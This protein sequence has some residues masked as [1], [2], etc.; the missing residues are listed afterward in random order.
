NDFT[1]LFRTLADDPDSYLHQDPA[2]F[3]SAVGRSFYSQILPSNTV[4]L[5]WTSWAVQW[6][7]RLPA[8]LPDH[9]QVAYSQ[10]EEARAAY[11]HHPATDW[12]DFLAFRGREL[13]PEGRLVVLT[14]AIGED[15]E[16]GYRPLNDTLVAALND[17]VRDGLLHRDELRRMAF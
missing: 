3:T 1:A 12:Q 4:N 16:F 13:C 7:S 14:M 17:Q 6:L 10:D 5:G 8:P 9:V 11:P 15:G 2:S